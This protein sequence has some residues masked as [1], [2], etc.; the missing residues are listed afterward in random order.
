MSKLE[1]Y[2]R[3]MTEI[4]QQQIVI[5]GPSVAL[6]K[7]RGVPGIFVDESGVVEDLDGEP[8]TLLQELI[9]A[10]VA[11]SGLIVTKA[12]EPLLKK[13]PS[14]ASDLVKNTP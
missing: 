11:L 14:L 13:Y 5:V 3:V 8:A 6:S 4:I 9:N 7:A 10:Y 2:R 1:D 12:T